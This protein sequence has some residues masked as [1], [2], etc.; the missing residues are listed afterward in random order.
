M[1]ATTS[2]RVWLLVASLGI[3][4]LVYAFFVEPRR[5]VTR[6]VEIP[7]PNL[8]QSP[9]KILLFS[10]V[11]FTGEGR[12]E[13][14]IRRIAE[15]FQ[16]D[17]VLIAGDLLDRL[18][19]IRVPAYVESA[20]RFLASLPA[21]FGRL[22]V[23]GEEEARE[24]P[25]LRAS[26]TDRRELRVLSAE[27]LLLR[28]HGEEIDLFGGDRRSD[29]APWGVAS[30]GIRSFLYSR[31][32]W[33]GQN[34]TYL[35]FPAESWND[36]EM[37][38]A[39]QA[40]A[41]RSYLDI[42]FGWSRGEDPAEESGWRLIRHGNRP[43]FILRGKYPGEHK[44]KGRVETSFV[45][46]P[47]VWCRARIR[48]EDDGESTRVRARFWLEQE[49]EPEIWM[50][51][52]VDRGPDRRRSGTIGFG[53]R[54]GGK[55]Y[56][57]LRVVSGDGT[58][59]MEEQFRDSGR[60]KAHWSQTSALSRWLRAPGE[61]RTRLL[62]AHDPD[63]ALD[64]MTVDEP[65]P[66]ILLA[67]HTHGGQIRLPG[68]GALFTDTELGPRYSAGE[69]EYRGLPL[70]ITAGVGTSYLPVR[71]FNPPEVTLLTLVPGRE[72]PSGG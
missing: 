27:S 49:R 69:L 3:A 32:R 14:R 30:D 1:L 34:L 70:Y 17:L 65:P 48:V 42:R 22:L 47:G 44:L 28:V 46:P 56:A 6:R 19:L 55:R 41:E 10:D 12:R 59:L 16:P 7:C 26:W 67:G 53:G 66:C 23:P 45:P 21:P 36:V 57:D 54:E 58:V 2:R 38:L 20:A 64:V 24:L 33:A 43:A 5:I 52:A 72:P 63:I 18:E 25:I 61:G 62:L 39:F 31:G 9:V 15:Q 11:D 13:R 71:L 4:L 8:R 60:F 37:T 68:V 51:D 35:G 40:L 50:V 29:P